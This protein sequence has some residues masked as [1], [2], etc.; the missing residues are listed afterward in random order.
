MVMKEGVKHD[1]LNVGAG[2][3]VKKGIVHIQNVTDYHKRL[4][5]WIFNRFHGVA[6]K[7]LENYLAWL[8]ELD[9]FEHKIPLTAILLRAK[10]GGNYKKLPLMRTSY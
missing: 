2:E 3:K 6:T 4:K 8:R 7:Y 1:C 9:E 5:E 10:N